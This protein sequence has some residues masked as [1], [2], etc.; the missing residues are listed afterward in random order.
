MMQ[1]FLWCVCWDLMNFE[2]MISYI[3]FGTNLLTQ[4]QVPVVVFPMFFTSREINIKRNPNATKLHGEFFGTRRH[5]MDQG[6]AWG[7]L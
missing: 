5:L 6:C 1:L 2:F 7:V 4:C 3:F